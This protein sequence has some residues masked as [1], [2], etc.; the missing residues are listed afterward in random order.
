M[1]AV[2][3]V[4][5]GWDYR[6]DEE[7]AGLSEIAIGGKPVALVPGAPSGVCVEEIASRGGRAVA[8]PASGRF[9]T[10]VT[11]RRSGE[12]ILITADVTD[13]KGGDSAADVFY[14]IPIDTA[15]WVWRKS[16]LTS[17]PV[18]EGQSQSEL[19]IAVATNPATGAGLAVAVTPET[20]CIFVSGCSKARGLF[21][22]ARVGFSG[23]TKPPSQA[24]ICFAVYPVDGEWGMRSALKQYYT[25][26][27]KAYGGRSKANG[28]WIFHGKATTAPNPTQFAFHALGELGE[29]RWL[30]KKAI[31]ILTPEEVKR[32][33][34]WGIEIYPYVIPG[35]REV[36]FLDHLKGEKGELRSTPE[37]DDAKDLTNTH[38]STAEALDLLE[39]MTEKN[40]TISQ[41][42]QPIPDYVATVKNSYL[43]GADGD[44]VTRPRVCPWA[45]KTVT[46]PM[47]PNPSI[48]GGEKR[49]NAGLTIL[50]QCRKW[51]E[52][53]WDG[54]YVDSLYRW[55]AYLSYRREH[56][57][58]A[59]YG[60]TYGPDGRPCLD[61]SLEHLAFLDELGK[62]VRS[63]GGEVAANG[64]RERC[65]FH[66]QR[67]DVAGSEFGTNTT[68]EG[69]AFRRSLMYHKPYMGMSHGMKGRD[70][71]R[72]YL[73][74]CFLFGLYA[75]SDM[76]Y[77]DTP[78]YPKVKDIYDTYLPIQREMCPLGWEP[79]TWARSLTDGV[80]VERFGEGPAVFFSL[81]RD[82]GDAG[83]A[84]VEV[85]CARLNLSRDKIKAVDP[86]AGREL[87]AGAVEDGKVMVRGVPL[88]RDG[89]GVLK[90][91]GR[92][93]RT[94]RPGGQ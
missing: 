39:H 55:G 69:M 65:F 80:L 48:P 42:I 62:L 45:D 29:C 24:R 26:F 88:S 57:A 11:T 76:P 44:I 21:V 86:V 73:A 35:Q 6:L 81:Y 92:D 40:V 14:H 79:V 2:C 19:P 66:A 15:G 37:D 60:L 49:L 63:K 10:R 33:K 13:T 50:D 47:N 85:D 84:D 58:Y 61:N 38:Y 3:L 36:G 53:S 5:A 91:E 52:G 56:F 64:V 20:P 31:D 68:L 46:F 82:S 54:I 87:Q 78:D 7:T 83:A 1:V 18:G 4:S 70:Q 16:V 22:K 9:S 12:A 75:D 25:L 41:M 34:A 28:L 94:V 72:R 59:R 27:P 90:I 89:I 17:A 93:A 71:D 67:L 74:R 51:L 32:E 23:L 8:L 77:F 43:I 30:G